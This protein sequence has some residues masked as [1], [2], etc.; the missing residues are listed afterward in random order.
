MVRSRKSPG[1]QSLLC[2]R[3]VRILKVGEKILN[4]RQMKIK[5]KYIRFPIVLFCVY[6][7]ENAALLF[8]KVCFWEMCVNSIKMKY[9]CVFQPIFW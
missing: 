5:E 3:H 8:V 7:R 6:F 2:H 1:S 9:E 4:E